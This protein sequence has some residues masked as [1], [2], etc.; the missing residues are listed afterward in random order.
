MLPVSTTWPFSMA[1]RYTGAPL[2]R[3]KK[4]LVNPP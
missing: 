4:A 1:Y 3:V 2:G